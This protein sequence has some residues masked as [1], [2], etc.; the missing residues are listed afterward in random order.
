MVLNDSRGRPLRDLRLSVTDRCNFRC[1]YCMPKTAFGPDHPFLRRSDLLRYEEIER[2]AGLLVDLGVRKIRLTGGEPLLRRD[3]P[4]LVSRLAAIEDVD[5]LSLT[6]NGVLLAGQAAGLARAGLQRVTVSLDS[7]DDATFRRMID[8]DVPVDTVLAGIDAARAAGLAPIKINAV[9]RRG[10]NDDTIVDLA[11]HFQGTGCV[12]RFIEYMDVGTTNGW[13]LDQVVTGEEILAR[14]RTAFDLRPVEPAYPGE[15][16]R[17][18]EDA[19]QGFELGIITA[20]SRPFCRTCT[21]LRLS[22]D[23]HLFTCLFASDGLDLRGPL[24][25][26][27]TD[28]GLRDRVARLW[29][30]RVDRYSEQRA[31]AT[32][33]LPR[34]EMS[35]IGG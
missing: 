20:V 32:A 16:A 9:V 30:G 27:V 22:P 19:A 5:D 21:R 18:Y 25:E 12:V 3:L 35:Y 7:V 15:V 4:D 26:G 28:A 14:L 8:A 10:V 17:R 24:R 31:G 34:I 23:G 6:T 13:R 29:A 1:G 11:R 33:G 2:L